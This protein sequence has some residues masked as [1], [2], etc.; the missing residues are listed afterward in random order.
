MDDVGVDLAQRNQRRLRPAVPGC[1]PPL[2]DSAE[3]HKKC[4]AAALDGSFGVFLG[5]SQIERTASV[6][7][8]KSTTSGGKSVN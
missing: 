5:E 8:R 4:S 1:L 6:G 2:T 3:C 7:S